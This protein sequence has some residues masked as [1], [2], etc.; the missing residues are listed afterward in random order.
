MMN[1]NSSK[2]MSFIMSTVYPI[3]SI[4]FYTVKNYCKQNK[5]MHA[6]LKHD[7]HASVQAETT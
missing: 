4:V 1:A 2:I 3:P 7:R 6:L 5:N